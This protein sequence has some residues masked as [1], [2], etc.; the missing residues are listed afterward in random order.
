M[1]LLAL[2][3]PSPKPKQACVPSEL[4][5]KEQHLLRDPGFMV[6]VSD[7]ICHHN[8]APNFVSSLLV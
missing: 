3:C 2:F 7:G 6:V 5:E 4:L 8:E 1:F